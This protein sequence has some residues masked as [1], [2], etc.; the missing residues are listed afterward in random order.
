MTHALRRKDDERTDFWTAPII[1][2]NIDSTLSAGV[3]AAAA[4]GSAAGVVLVPPRPRPKSPDIVSDFEVRAVKLSVER[5]RSASGP[6]S[7]SR[8]HTVG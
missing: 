3:A 1:W 7:A 2:A 5:A 8:L 6:T 4:A